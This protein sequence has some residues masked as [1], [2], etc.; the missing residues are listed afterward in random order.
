VIT[1]SPA[2]SL[3]EGDLNIIVF[4]IYVLYVRHA[5]ALK[6]E[7]LL[8]LSSCKSSRAFGSRNKAV[9]ESSR[10]AE[11]TLWIRERRTSSIT[12]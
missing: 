10:V 7:F 9:M 1:V 12:R 4:D 2:C 11:N 5:Y 6:L 3:F 8:L